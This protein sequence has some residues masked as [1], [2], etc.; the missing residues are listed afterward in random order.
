MNDEIPYGYCQCGCGEKAAITTT[1]NYARGIAKGDPL[2]Y[3]YGHRKKIYIDRSIPLANRRETSRQRDKENR[4]KLKLE[5]LGYYSSGEP[6]CSCCGNK[7]IHHLTIDHVDGGGAE[8]RKQMK[9][10]SEFYRW[11]KK[12]NYPPR[13][14]VLCFNC[15]SAKYI[16]GECGCQNKRISIVPVSH[17]LLGKYRKQ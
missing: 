9:G 17:H 16:E 3:A 10:G 2:M 1:T 6:R 14:Q 12:N 7:Y 13:F 5:V 15:N 8:H 4:I 11:L